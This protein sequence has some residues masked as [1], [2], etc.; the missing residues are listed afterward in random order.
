[1][2][3]RLTYRLFGNFL[4]RY[5]E[6]KYALKIMI[7]EDYLLSIANTEFVSSRGI[8]ANCDIRPNIPKSS[9]VD[10]IYLDSINN[11]IDLYEDKKD[12]PITL[13][14]CTD[15]VPYFSSN[16][17]PQITKPFTLITGD[18]DLSV[19][20]ATM[21]KSLEYLLQHKYLVNWFAQNRDFYHPR[22]HSLPIG[23][24]YHSLWYDPKLWGGGSILPSTQEC[25]IRKANLNSPTWEKRRLLAYCDWIFSINHGKRKECKE[26]LDPKLCYYPEFRLSRDKTW[27]TQTN[28][29]FVASP[30]GNG[31]DCHR[32]WEAIALG[33]VPIIEINQCNDLFANL[34]VIAVENWGQINSDFLQEQY[35]LFLE[36]KFELDS[37]HLSYW[38]KKIR[39]A[40]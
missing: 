30:S 39:S 25:L 15:G 22:L 28:Y 6:K 2:P 36:K 24:D 33:A 21:G 31:I 29:A 27:E 19:S 38:I 8:L 20:L 35:D 11:Q 7:E 3:R 12:S 26:L 40:Q 5:D 37:L 13:Y 23:L 9:Y 34:P 10:T 4:K 1:M 18:S 17:A 16:V 32:T 14:V